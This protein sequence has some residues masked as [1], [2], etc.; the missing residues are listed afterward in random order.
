VI[1]AIAFVV[2]VIS[3]IVAARGR[4][5]SATTEM[6]HILNASG[7]RS[8]AIGGNVKGSTIVTGDRNLVGNTVGGD[9]VA[10]DKIIHIHQAS[11][12]VASA[13]HQIPPPPAD[14]TGREEE[15]IELLAAIEYG[16][17]TISGLQGL[18]GIG[19]TALAVKLVQQ[20][21][22]RYPDA[23]FYLDLRGTSAQP[24][25]VSEVSAHVVRAYHPTAKLP[26]SETDLRGLYFSVLEGQ[27]AILLM[28]NAASAAQVE[29]LIP[30]AS[31]LLLVTSRFHFTLPGLAAKHLD[32]LNP[33]DAREL[34]LTIA[35]RIAERA[36]EIAALCGYL[37]LALRLAAGAIVKYI[38]LKPADYVQRLQDHQQR[39]KLIEASLS[40]SYE[41]LSEELKESWRCLAVFPD[42]FDA[43]AAAA[44]WEVEEE[45]AGD[46]LAELISASLAEWNET[47]ERYRL[48]D[49]AR[50]F[51][52]S[53]LSAEERAAAQKRFA[54]HYHVM[55]TVA[56]ELYKEGGEAMLWGLTLFDLEWDNIQAGH[57]WVAAQGDSSDEDV[58]RLAI[59][60]PDTGAYVLHLRQ[61]SR[62]RI[63]WLEIALSAARRL[64]NRLNES[65]ALGNLGIAYKNLGEFRRAIQFQ[66]QALPI[67]REIGNRR[68]EAQVLSNLGNAYNYL[69]ETSPALQFLEQALVIA[70]EIGD[71]RGEGVLLG[72]IGNSYDIMGQPHQAIQFHEKALLIHREIGDRRT[73]AMNLGNV[74]TAYLNL[75]EP[76]RA[77]QYYKRALLIVREIGDR[78]GE[79]IGLWNMSL[80]LDQSGY[81]AQAVQH[82]KQSLT[83]LEQIEDP[84]AERVRARLAAWRAV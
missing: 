78:S 6:S 47:S 9:I 12:S 26:D 14:F 25:S 35:P 37:P 16:G 11:S 51:A 56:N 53:K 48:H 62:D 70:R 22:S 54:T 60:Y 15:Q 63:R 21:K 29:P 69:R 83:I 39:L 50:L 84:N 23:Q 10:R 19:K 52:D 30:P 42:T 73:E 13:L 24:L 71:R 66:E 75:G 46:R 36:D 82:A 72:N 3:A 33:E 59:A 38:N 79:G 49:L 67:T 80:A 43:Y 65:V 5:D 32:T 34:L 41:L 58:P 81:R 45:Q 44:I 68:A 18:G 77:I 64:K 74:G 28:D 76:D 40:L 17:I 57:A 1:C 61:H 2:T 55:L 27:R 7:K 8:V 4:D 31:C 20:L